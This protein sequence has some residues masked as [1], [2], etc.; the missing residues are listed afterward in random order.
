MFSAAGGHNPAAGTLTR[1]GGRGT[2]HRMPTRARHAGLLARLAALEARVA[3]LEARR[4]K[5]GDG[6]AAVE[7]LPPGTQRCPGCGLALRR[8]KGR[9]AECGFPLDLAPA[10][11]R[12]GRAKK[13]TRGE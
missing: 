10:A 6:R 4:A 9:C 5:P 11:S 7:P 13:K 12:A 3:R 2:L 1:R 8:R